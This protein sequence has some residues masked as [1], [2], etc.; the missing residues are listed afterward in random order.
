[1]VATPNLEQFHLDGFMTSWALG[2]SST[3]DKNN[4]WQSLTHLV[5]GPHLR[6]SLNAAFAPWNSRFLPPLASTLRSIEI[7]GVMP[8]VAH[9]VLFAT[10][11]DGLAPG[12]VSGWGP[13]QVESLRPHLPNLE[14]FR[15]IA[16]LAHP[17]VMKDIL[18]TAAQNGTLK[19]LELGATTSTGFPLP[20][21]SPSPSVAVD[22]DFQPLRDYDFAMSE[23]LH[24]LG[25][26]DFNFHYDQNDRYGTSGRFDGQPFLDWIEF[27]PELHTVGVYPGQWDGVAAFIMRLIVHPRVKT[28]HQEYLKGAAWDEAKRLAEKTGTTLLH[29]PKHMP[30]GWPMIMD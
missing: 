11:S 28:I 23:N 22:T 2:Q 9:N 10:D 8:D 24:T 20:P 14:V 17:R 1:M 6:Y 19:V 7:L 18:E 30:A 25:L 29:T 12:Q 27:F 15:Y 21:A 16:G 26:H 5:L 4:L 3:P 13:P